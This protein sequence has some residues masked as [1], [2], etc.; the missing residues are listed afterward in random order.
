MNTYNGLG[1][2]DEEVGQYSQALE[3]RT[4]A[5]SLARSWDRMD[6]LPILLNNLASSLLF[7]GRLDEAQE[8]ANEG[9][10]VARRS[11]A[12]SSELLLLKLFG[13]IADRRG[14]KEEARDSFSS[15]L[16][17][18]REIGAREE[19]ANLILILANYVSVCQRTLSH[20]SQVTHIPFL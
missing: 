13:S 17:L 12:K 1:I 19:E 7:F 9:L 10:T 6:V 18:A 14:R 5:V 11:G 4:E 8:R 3:H 16:S 15:A 20:T 2:L